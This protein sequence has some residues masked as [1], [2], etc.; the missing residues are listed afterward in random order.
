M[1]QEAIILDYKAFILN[2]FH[3]THGSYCYYLRCVVKRGD[4]MDIAAIILA[5]EFNRGRYNPYRYGTSDMQLFSVYTSLQ[6]SWRRS[7]PNSVNSTRPSGQK[8]I[9]TPRISSSPRMRSRRWSGNLRSC[10]PIPWHPFHETYIHTY[11]IQFLCFL[12]QYNQ[13]C[14][15]K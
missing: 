5:R 11:H 3:E 10:T 7:W 13:Y 15:T 4:T 12:H 14:V 6:K 9:Y 1:G 2:K 8:R